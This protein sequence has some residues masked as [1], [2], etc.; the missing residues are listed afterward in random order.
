MVS[1]NNHKETSNASQIKTFLVITIILTAIVYFWMFTTGGKNMLSVAVMMWVPGIAAIIT[2][3][4]L[5]TKISAL[6]WKPKKIRYLIYAYLFPAAVAL[7]GYGIMW[8]GKVTDFYTDE[9]VNYRWVHMLGFDTPAP[10]IIGIL[11]KVIFASL[12]A[13]IFVLGEEIGWSAFLV[14]RLLKRFSVPV[15]SIIVGLFW[16]VWHYPAIIAGIY[17]YDIPLWVA[18]P[19]FTM[20]LTGA[21]FFRTVLIAK[22]ESFWPGVIIHVSHNIVLMSI[23]RE[24][25]VKTKYSDYWVSETGLFLG[26]VYLISGIVYWLIQKKNID[27]PKPKTDKN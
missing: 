2:A 27:Y 18:L 23:F 19:G 5:K 14:P 26:I 12:L 24:M 13:F 10:F 6:G 20:V 4:M 25:T 16:S 17:G 11:S 1:I 8:L 21:S 15:T 22:S 7:I 3:V 9:V